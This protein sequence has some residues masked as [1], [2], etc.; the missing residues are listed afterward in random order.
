[1]FTKVNNKVNNKD[2][3][4][5]S[6]TLFWCSYYY[7]ICFS[8]LS[9]VSISDLKQAFILSRY[10]RDYLSTGLFLLVLFRAL[11]QM[12]PLLLQLCM[13]PMKNHICY[14][15]PYGIRGRYNFFWWFQVCFIWLGEILI[16]T[17]NLD[18]LKNFRIGRF[19]KFKI[20]QNPLGSRY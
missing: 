18:F 19:L 14:W 4:T 13:I 2:I 20:A 3:R 15:T 6:L 8:P 10:E 16:R 1:M 7:C 5:T 9:S 11:R 12:Q 17:G